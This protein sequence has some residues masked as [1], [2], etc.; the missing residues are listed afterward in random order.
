MEKKLLMPIIMAMLIL[1]SFLS[2]CV[3]PWAIDTL[4]WDHMN[5]E[6]TSVRIWGQLTLTENMQNW[7]VGFV[8]DIEPHDSWENYA[9][10]EE[11]DNY[12]GL[13]TYSLIIP[14]LDRTTTYH[15][16]AWGENKGGNIR[17]G[18]DHTFVPGGPR[19]WT[20]NASNIGT[21]YATLNGYI[22]HLGGAETCEVFFEY[23][24]DQEYLDMETEHQTID[25]IGSF[26]A[27]ITDLESCT[28]YYYR[29]IARNDADIWIG[30]KFTV[31]PGM[32]Q[33]V[34][35]TPVDIEATTATFEC[36]INHLGGTETC[37]IWFEYSDQSPNNLD[38][39]TSIITVNATGPLSILVENLDP[40][41][42]YWLRAVGNNGV[43]ENR[44]EI[45]EFKTKSGLLEISDYEAEKETENEKKNTESE[46]RKTTQKSLIDQIQS[47]QINVD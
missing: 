34:T 39:T 21:T 1:V 32:P 17:V 40:E 36:E 20:N 24:I 44:G 18:A 16:R 2:G 35:R 28:T 47:R 46:T 13:N 15:Y 23:G 22:Y 31:Q 4:G 12:E 29:A 11:A 45:K 10:F 8:W 9:N 26:N 27:E 6:G 43:C 37:D 14:G 41:T 42:T 30:A 5:E 19:V 3:G 33:L 38:E 25:E 7:N